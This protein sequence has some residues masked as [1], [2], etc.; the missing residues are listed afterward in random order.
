VK[1]PGGHKALDEWSFFLC[2]KLRSVSIPNGITR[3]ASGTFFGLNLLRRVDIPN[4]RYCLDRALSAK[5]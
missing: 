1:L 5:K 3:I 4:I 2:D